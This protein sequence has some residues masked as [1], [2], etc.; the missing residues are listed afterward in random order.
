MPS[1]I[2]RIA[3]LGVFGALLATL[4]WIAQA[5]RGFEKGTAV[6][7]IKVDGLTRQYL[8]HVPPRYWSGG[9]APLVLVL[10]GATQSPASAEQM[11]GM[12]DLADRN[13]FVVAYPR[14]TGNLPMWNA[15]NCCGSA[16]ENKVDDVAFIH[17]L[18]GKIESKYSIDSRRIYVTGISNGAMMSY[19]VAC[20]LSGEVAAVAPVEGAQN[21][22]CQPA[23]P[24]SVIVFHGTADNLVPYNGGTTPFQIGPK[25]ADTSV[26]HTV[27]FW[28]HEDGCSTAPERQDSAG[29]RTS[30]YSGCKDGTGVAL[31]TIEGGHH[32]WPGRPLSGNN[33]P[34]TDLM[35]TFFSEH[36]KSAHAE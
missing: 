34:A 29:L 9:K 20:E 11:S 30:I 12:S 16:L 27:K 8:L 26:A 36:P 10:H 21:L 25:R 13:I 35:W 28:V 3:T 22:D 15:G 31:Y 23:N 17:A 7:T 24:V 5:A 18:I 6:E 32:M 33:V 1:L 19:R 14:G 2:R 4:P